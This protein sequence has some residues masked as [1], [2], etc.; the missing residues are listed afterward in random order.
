[1]D[2]DVVA[3]NSEEVRVWFSTS[4]GVQDLSKLSS[5][6]IAQKTTTA[7]NNAMA[8]IRSMSQRVA[9]T[10]R[11]LELHERPETVELKFAL[12]LTSDGTVFIASAGIET[13]IEV[14]LIWNSRTE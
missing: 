2:E 4:G 3:D 13:Q 5:T 8:S 9:N 11:L 12:K 1:M 6:E 7:L 10:F 14:K